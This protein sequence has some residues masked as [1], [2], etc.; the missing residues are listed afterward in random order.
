[1]S[2]GPVLEAAGT[3]PAVVAF[4]PA[5]AHLVGI[6]GAIGAVLRHWV[7]LQFSSGRFPWPT[8]SVNVIGSFVFALAIFTGAGE[9]TVYLLGIG[10]C[11][12]FTTFSSFSVETVQ[13]YERGDRLLAAV[14][15]VGNLVLSVSAIGLA[16]LVVAVGPFLL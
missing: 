15:A 8:L 9:S 5:P 6:G 12:A 4:E 7:Y 10:V 2:G 14:N 1:M 16:W 13:L 3:L 11:G